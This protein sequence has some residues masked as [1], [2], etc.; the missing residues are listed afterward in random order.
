MRDMFGN[1]VSEEGARLLLKVRRGTQPKGY[2]S[3][4]G[5]GPS[6]ETCGTCAHLYR[7]RLAKTYLKC[8]LMSRIWTGGRATDVLARSPA[9]RNWAKPAPEGGE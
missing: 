3:Q 4:P 6:G 1:E 9:C 5:T 8:A 2:A 7:N